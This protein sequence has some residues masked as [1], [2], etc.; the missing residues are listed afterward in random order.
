MH[1]YFFPGHTIFSYYYQLYNNRA[2]FRLKIWFFND[3]F[4]VMILDI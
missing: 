3:F 2:K 4:G 1:G